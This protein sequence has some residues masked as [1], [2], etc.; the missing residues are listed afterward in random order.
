MKPYFVFYI[1]TPRVVCRWKLGTS[2]PF[3]VLTGKPEACA[4]SQRTTTRVLYA[5]HASGH[6]PCEWLTSGFGGLNQ[7]CSPE[8]HRQA[9][10]DSDNRDDH[11]VSLSDAEVICTTSLLFFS[12]NQL[13]LTSDMNIWYR[14]RFLWRQLSYQV[15]DWNLYLMIS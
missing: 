15:C 6:E 3:S 10:H 13:Q 1:P 14:S 12:W 5:C 7:S 11:L 8:F 9:N 2:L 4:C